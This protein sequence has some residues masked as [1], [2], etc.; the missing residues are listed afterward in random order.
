MAFDEWAHRIFVLKD[1]DETDYSPDERLRIAIE[2][3]LNA[4]RLIDMYDREQL[5]DGLWHFN[6]A[7]FQPIYDEALPEQ[8]RL[9]C[10]AAI[11]TLYTDLFEPY[12]DDQLGHDELDDRPPNPPLNTMCYMWWDTFPSWG[13]PGDPRAQTI[14]QALL[15]LMGGQLDNPNMAIVEGGLHGLGHWHFRYPD[16]TTELVD[17]FLSRHPRAH[18]VLRRYA[19]WARKGH[20]L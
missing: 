14:D 15:G 13:H 5:R 17:G 7:F 19:T 8:D 10:V 1:E 16:Q 11:R 9:A 3:C 6:G 2:V 12:C 18:P 4:G 20:V